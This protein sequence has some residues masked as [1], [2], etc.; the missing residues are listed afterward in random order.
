[1]VLGLF[2]MHPMV[3]WSRDNSIGPLDAKADV[4]LWGALAWLLLLSAVILYVSRFPER[5]FP[6]QFD[7]LGN[8]HNLFHVVVVVSSCC[9][10]VAASR[11]RQFDW[12]PIAT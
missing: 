3:E 2:L 5:W 1:V 9:A 12:C 7:T 10:L 4:V 6:G 11:V 8:S